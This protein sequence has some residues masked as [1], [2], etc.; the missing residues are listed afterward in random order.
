[1][2]KH[3]NQ[4]NYRPLSNNELKFFKDEGYLILKNVLTDEG[5]E[6]NEGRMYERVE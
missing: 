4:F 2:E 6:K 1:M 3:S 5:L